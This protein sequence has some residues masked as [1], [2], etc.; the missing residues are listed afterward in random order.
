M[1]SVLS[2]L[3]NKKRKLSDEGKTFHY[4]LKFG[5][6]EIIEENVIDLNKGY[7]GDIEEN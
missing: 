5:A 7:G 4:F 3:E 6:I 1:Y 2:K